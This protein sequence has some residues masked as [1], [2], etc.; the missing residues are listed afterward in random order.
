MSPE[1]SGPVGAVREDRAPFVPVQDRVAAQ[2]SDRLALLAGESYLTYGELN[3]RANQLA[4]LLCDRR[5]DRARPVGI[6]LERSADFVVAILGVLRSGHPYLPFDP[7]QPRGRLDDRLRQAGAAALVTRSSLLAE[8]TNPD[9]PVLLVDRE[10]QALARE[11]TS[12]PGLPVAAEDLAY[13]LFTSGTTGG[14]KCVEVVHGGLSAYPDAFNARL[15]IDADAR[16]LHVASFAFSAAVRQLFVPLSLGATVALASFEQ[17]HDPLGLLRWVKDED[18]TVLDWVPSYLRQVCAA[19]ASLAPAARGDLMDHRVEMLVSSGEAL[20]WAL[21]RRWRD[22]CGFRGRI[23]NAYG[24]TETTGL[25]AWYEVPATQPD[26]DSPM[27]AMGCAVPPAE[28]H[29]LND[30]MVP[31]PAGIPGDLW[32]AGPCV[33]RAYRGGGPAMLKRPNPFSAWPELL[34]T[35]DKVRVDAGGVIHFEGRC[36]D[37]VKVR[38]VRLTLGDVEEALRSHPSVQDAAVVVREDDRGEVRIH[39]FLE[40]AVGAST[41]EQAVRRHLRE[42]GADY[43]VPHAIIWSPGLPRTPSGKADRPALALSLEA[44]TG[45]GATPAEP[46]GAAA[47]NVYAVVREA[48]VDALGTDAEDGDFF[49][50]GGDS[51]Q[52]IAM[53]GRITTALRLDKPLIAAFFGDPTL[54]GLL[55]VISD[56]RTAELSAPLVPRPRGRR[57]LGSGGS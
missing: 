28:L 21:V 50:L 57:A 34:A 53:L 17:I 2:P 52:V 6:C 15:A 20:S 54:K 36:D 4:R 22:D 43:L 55:E 11:S 12:T 19:L 56:G 25:V 32:V 30:A 41:D 13:S 31:L 18:I 46:S 27:V 10:R 1:P 40:P 49:E 45:D 47:A 38:G 26:P 5:L 35:G 7:R 16:Y 3:A 44:G 42:C 9:L 14:P 48:W 8:T 37:Q 24:Q 29:C 39:A 51:L 23:A 33:A